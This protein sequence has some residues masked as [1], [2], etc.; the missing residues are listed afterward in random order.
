MS[1]CAVVSC[2]FVK[3]KDG[4]YIGLIADYGAPY[5]RD[6]CKLDYWDDHVYN[7][8]KPDFD[9]NA[10]V[11]EFQR[12]SLRPRSLLKISFTERYF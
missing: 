9:D 8:D 12:V 4:P 5:D 11:I 2:A 10:S 1:T 3:I 6:N 7:Y